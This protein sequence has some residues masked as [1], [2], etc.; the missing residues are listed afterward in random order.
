MDVIIHQREGFNDEIT[1]TAE[2][3]PPGVHSVP[4]VI[5]NKFKDVIVSPLGVYSNFDRVYTE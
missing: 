1:L 2:N 4:T 5:N 3:L